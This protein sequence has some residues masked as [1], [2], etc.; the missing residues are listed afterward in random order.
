MVGVASLQVLYDRNCA[1]ITLFESYEPGSA[2]N[3]YLGCSS[4]LFK[5][6]RFEIDLV[7]TVGW[8]RCWPPRVRPLGCGVA[9]TSAGYGNP[10]DF[11]ACKGC[12]KCH[13]V[14]IVSRKSSVSDFLGY[15]QTPVYLHRACGH[16]IAFCGR[17]YPVPSDFHHCYLDTTPGQIQC[18]G[19][20]NRTSTNDKYGSLYIV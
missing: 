2:V 16:V 19:Q 9:I 15:P 7:D 18:Q 8:L 11:D 20:A 6:D 10:R 14:G 3:R 4:S 17:G 1:M 12:T 5:Q 13:I